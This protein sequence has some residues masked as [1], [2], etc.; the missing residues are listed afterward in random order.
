MRHVQDEAVVPK[1]EWQLRCACSLPHSSES[2]HYGSS[3]LGDALLTSLDSL[4]HAPGA[5]PTSTRSVRSLI[6]LHSLSVCRTHRNA[7]Q[8]NA[9]HRTTPRAQ[10]RGLLVFTHCGPADES[11]ARGHRRRGRHAE[12]GRFHRSLTELG[13][14]VS[15]VIAG[16]IIRS[17]TR[18]FVDI[19]VHL[20]SRFEEWRE[21]TQ[22]GGRCLR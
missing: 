15:R 1:D 11:P 14:Q 4:H 3:P 17:H 18:R 13:S 20:V 16:G 5:P 22:R 21:I 7:T 2:S 8:R 10:T 6:P 19:Y 9:T 12:L